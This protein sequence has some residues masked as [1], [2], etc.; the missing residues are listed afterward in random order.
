MCTA[1]WR[2]GGIPQIMAQCAFENRDGELCV[3]ARILVRYVG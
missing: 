2:N 1:V 3:L